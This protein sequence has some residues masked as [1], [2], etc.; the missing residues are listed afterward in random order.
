MKIYQIYTQTLKGCQ[1]SKINETINK[2]KFNKESV[3]RELIILQ[4]M[5]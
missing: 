4:S 1:I 3:R 2:Y 5:N